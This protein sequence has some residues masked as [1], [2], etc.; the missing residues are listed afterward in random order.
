MPIVYDAAFSGSSH[1]K[2][3]VYHNQG[4]PLPVGWALDSRG[5]PTTDPAAALQG[6]LLPI[7]GFKGTGLAMIMGILSSLLSGAAYGT[8]LGSMEA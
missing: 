8:E 6:L 1:G 4:R 5:A 2:I 7:G 3:R